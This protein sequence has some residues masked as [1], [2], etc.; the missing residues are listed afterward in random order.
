MGVGEANEGRHCSLTD[1]VSHNGYADMQKRSKNSF[2]SSC[3]VLN[4]RETHFVLL[5]THLRQCVLGLGRAG[6]RNV[7]PPANLL[8]NGLST[9]PAERS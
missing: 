4:Q 9:V 7:G 8:V 1:A 3:L 2:H 5:F 6:Q